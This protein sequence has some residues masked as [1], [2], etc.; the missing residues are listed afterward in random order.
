MVPCFFC[1]GIV[2][3]F[4]I[5]ANLKGTS[6]NARYTLRYGHRLKAAARFKSII[7]NAR[8]TVRDNNIRCLFSVNIQIG[9]VKSPT[10][11]TPSGMTADVIFWQP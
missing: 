11:V 2:N 7:P 3:I 10:L 6:A 5:L 9:K 1:A 8:H 4:E